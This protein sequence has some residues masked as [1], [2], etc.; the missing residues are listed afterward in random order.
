M[1]TR[2]AVKE[3]TIEEAR[4]QGNHEEAESVIISGH[5]NLGLTIGTVVLVP[6]LPSDLVDPRHTAC[7][8]EILQSP[9]LVCVVE[10]K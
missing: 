7:S 1:L 9:D 8:R 2:R 4:R 6:R 3:S 5:A 10:T